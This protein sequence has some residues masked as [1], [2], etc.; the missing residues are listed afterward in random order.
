[1]TI[2]CD[3]LRKPS[4]PVAAIML[5]ALALSACD[6][7]R[8]DHLGREP[9]F[10]E[11]T[12]EPRFP[13][14]NPRMEEQF[15]GPIIDRSYGSASQLRPGPQG[16]YGAPGPSSARTYGMQRTGPIPAQAQE[17]AYAPS[18]FIGPQGTGSARGSLWSNDPR[19][20]F[21][22]RRA[23]TVG[24]ILTIMIEI[25][26]EASINNATSRQRAGSEAVSTRAVFGLEGLA[27]SLISNVL[28]GEAKTDPALDATSS[29][30]ASGQ[31][32]VTRNESISL[33]VAARVIE[34]LPNGHLVI[35][36]RQ[37]VRVNFELR[38]LQVTGII[39]PE[40]ITRNND[41]TYD[42][43]AEA[44]ISY[45]GRGQITDVQQPRLGQQVIDMVS[46]F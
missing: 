11:M 40:D 3:T 8:F 18:P 42:K 14:R 16:T 46:P 25:D 15:P 36:G 12:R 33:K 23:K 41:I 17:V 38:D 31:G 37:E 6:T 1:M 7:S 22:D 20:L 43:M 24:D 30:N 29:S 5:S 32:Q 39:R 13:P 10:T 27:T 21:G 9:S 4:H 45:G 44:R 26:D 2:P 19:S 35:T 28:P 34:I